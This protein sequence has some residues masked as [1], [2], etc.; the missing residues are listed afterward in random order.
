MSSRES[1]C[2]VFYH[3]FTLIELLVVIAIIAILAGMLLPALNRARSV[4]K[5][6]GC[7]SNLKQVGTAWSMYHQENNDWV[8]PYVVKYEVNYFAQDM[9][10]QKDVFKLSNRYISRAENTNLLGLTTNTMLCPGRAKHLTQGNDTR[11]YMSVADYS[12]NQL[13]NNTTRDPENG[14]TYLKK[15]TGIKNGQASK[16]MVFTDDQNREI[17]KATNAEKYKLGVGIQWLYN[18]SHWQYML[19]HPAG[20]TQ[21]F[22]DGH[23]ATM[24]GMWYNNAKTYCYIDTWNNNGTPVYWGLGK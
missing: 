13:I 24:R 23:A 1:R 8:L 15:I 5:Q 9:I 2:P 6:S 12:Y 4:A 18:G 21:L 11:E 19:L 17:L 16:V 10:I 20:A 22:A 7:Q 14:A 3:S